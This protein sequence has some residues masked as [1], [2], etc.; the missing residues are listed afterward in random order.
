MID[1]CYN[2]K[3]EASDFAHTISPIG[4][5]IMRKAFIEFLNDVRANGE[6]IDGV[7]YYCRADAECKKCDK[8][9]R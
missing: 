4:D 6:L 1:T 9:R 8:M 2:F 3:I 7:I 5:D